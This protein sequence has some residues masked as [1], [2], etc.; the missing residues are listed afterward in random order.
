MKLLKVLD[1]HDYA[2]SMNVYEKY[3]VRGII[4][5]N[6]KLA[7]Q[8]ANNGEYKIPGGTVEKGE[9]LINALYREIKEETGLLIDKN[10]I[11]ELGEV[12]EIRRDR[13]D[14]N[15]KYICH[16]YY[17]L[18]SNIADETLEVNMTKH[19]IEQGYKLDWETLYNIY[20]TNNKLI[21]EEW[22]K[23]DT[24]FIKLIINGKIQL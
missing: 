14:N 22:K 6:G 5:N 17:Y 23:R 3:A 15:K 13:K 21:K 7:M 9:S 20:N 1:L 16:S 18:C 4:Y 8:K 12:T 24:E 19:E 2:E 10:S 11:S